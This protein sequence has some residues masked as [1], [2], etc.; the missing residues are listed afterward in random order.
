MIESDIHLRHSHP[1]LARNLIEECITGNEENAM[2]HNNY[3][4]ILSYYFREYSNAF[5]EYQKAII[6]KSDFGECYYNL[7][8]LQYFQLNE[9]DNARANYEL[10]MKFRPNI[11]EIINNY[12][13]L[14][15][16]NS[17]GKE[18]IELAR[19]LCEYAIQIEP[20]NSMIRG[21]Y[22]QIL[23]EHFSDYVEARKQ[24]EISVA[25]EDTEANAHHN[26]GVF[27]RLHLND[28]AIAEAEFRIAVQMEPE[29]VAYNAS[30]SE[31]LLNDLKRF[32]IALPFVEKAAALQPDNGRAQYNLSHNLL[33][34]FQFDRAKELY[35]KAYELDPNM[36]DESFDMLY[37]IIRA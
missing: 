4:V 16:N 18:D 3:G 9:I 31:L 28:L 34:L 30:L 35:I 22:A 27:A 15:K 1:K 6:L 23:V 32:D 7:A 25:Q 12:V 26:Y 19:E 11:I 14:L 21:L 24:F 5:S 20:T 8:N 36:I 17:R 37:G 33:A 29:N 2:L 13:V 10:A